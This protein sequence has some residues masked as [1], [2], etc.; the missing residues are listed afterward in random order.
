MI[1]LPVCARVNYVVP[2]K[3]PGM[4]GD[5]AT[6]IQATYTDLAG[7]LQYGWMTAGSATSSTLAD[8]PSSYCEAVQPPEWSCRQVTTADGITM[9][10]QPCYNQTLRVTDSDLKRW[11][12]F[13]YYGAYS[14]QT[15]KCGQGNR[16]DLCFVKARATMDG[17]PQEGWV[18]VFRTSGSFT[19]SV[20][21]FSQGTPND[22]FVRS[23]CGK[24][25]TLPS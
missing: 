10:K 3:F 9:F 5:N 14:K 15:S 4:C 25:N 13:L 22:V 16:Q 11:D 19:D 17:K 2:N 24:L 6:W 20:C 1:H 23:Y 8:C 21:S 7:V 12:T 18:P